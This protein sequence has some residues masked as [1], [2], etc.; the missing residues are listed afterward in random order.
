MDDFEEIPIWNADANEDIYYNQDMDLEIVPTSGE[1]YTDYQNVADALGILHHPSL[2][3][4]SESPDAEKILVRGVRLDMGTIISLSKAIPASKSLVRIDLYHVK[5]YKEGLDVLSTALVVS[6]VKHLRLEYNPLERAPKRAPPKVEEKSENGDADEAEGEAGAG[7]AVAAEAAAAEAEEEDSSEEDDEEEDE[8]EEAVEEEEEEIIDP[9]E[10]LSLKFA[11]L[12]ELQ[13]ISLWLRG[14]KITPEC[15]QLIRKK[16]AGHNT[17][18]ELNLADN[19][20]GDVGGQAL[21][22]ALYLNRSLARVSLA[23]NGLSHESAK[24]FSAPLINPALPDH[25]VEARREMD[26]ASVPNKDSKK[27]KG[28]KGSKKR[29]R[30]KNQEVTTDLPDVEVTPDGYTSEVNGVLQQ[31]DLS[32]NAIGNGV[33]HVVNGLI[34]ECSLKWLGLQSNGAKAE[35]IEETRDYAE[36]NFPEINISV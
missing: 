10:D 32:V 8:E 1:F 26:P 5:I 11:K 24:R 34:P 23:R 33:Q 2:S 36:R 35:V 12:F 18:V 7:D 28:S 31:L 20:L 29:K 9:N 13:L 30:K 22:D 4:E 3:N 14:N 6:P 19:Q 15:G 25:I 16:L 21:A 17:L 27:S